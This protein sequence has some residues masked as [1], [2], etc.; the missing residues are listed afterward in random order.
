MQSH[1][2]IYKIFR[3]IFLVQQFLKT[4]G[5]EKEKPPVE[6]EME[7]ADELVG[8]HNLIF[9]LKWKSEGS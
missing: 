5:E 6:E 3:F 2:S 8:K 1:S 9:L 7:D 4:E